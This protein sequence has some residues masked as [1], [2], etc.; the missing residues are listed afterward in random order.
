MIFSHI[1][2]ITLVL[3]AFVSLSAPTPAEFLRVFVDRAQL[4]NLPRDTSTIIIGKPDIVDISSLGHNAGF[5]VTG[6]GFGKTNVLLLDYKG[7][8]VGEKDIQVDPEP[9]DNIL[10]VLRGSD[11][12]FYFCDP[13][14]VPSPVVGYSAL[15]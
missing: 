12:Q 6:K 14:C 1:S 9:K 7:N 3:L 5:V 8:V 4:I 15:R 2:R 13:N 11:E 10:S